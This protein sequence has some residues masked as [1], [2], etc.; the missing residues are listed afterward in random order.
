[1]SIIKHGAV[2]HLV[3]MLLAQHAL[4]Q[5]EAIMGL[6]VLT[7]ICQTESEELLIE[8]GF[9]RSM[10]EFFEARANSLDVHIVLNA[11]TLLDSV[12][13]S[14]IWKIHREKEFEKK[15]GC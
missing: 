8:A 11:L 13:R 10:R 14:G 6:T 15:I 1:M 5:N 9:G 2:Q 3:N 7:R 12:V 4:M